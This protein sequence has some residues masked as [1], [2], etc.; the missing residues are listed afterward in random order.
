MFNIYVY[1]YAQKAIFIPDSLYNYRL[2]IGS[3]CHQYNVAQVQR[4]LKL[5]DAIEDYVEGMDWTKDARMLYQKRIL[6]SLI[7]ACKVDFCH[8]DNPLDYIT[9]RKLFDDLCS[10]EPFNSAMKINIIC[11]FSLKKQICMWFLKLRLF[12]LLCIFLNKI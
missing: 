3:T 9:R 8:K 11:R 5:L 12:G 2:L 7:N 10:K 1:T 6:V 4:I